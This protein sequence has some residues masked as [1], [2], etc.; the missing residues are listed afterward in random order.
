LDEARAVLEKG[1]SRHRGSVPILVSLG[2]CYSRL[3]RFEEA[4]ACYEHAQKLDPHEPKI[5]FNKA[6]ALSNL[7]LYE[8][9]R[10]IVVALLR[11]WPGDP[12]C[13]SLMGHCYSEMGSPEEA[14]KYLKKALEHGDEDPLTYDNLYWAYRDMGLLDDAIAL[15]QESIRKFPDTYPDLYRDLAGGYLELNWVEEARIV[16][17]KGLS[18]FPYDQDLKELLGALDDDT[19]DGGREEINSISKP[20][21]VLIRD[22][23]QKR[24]LLF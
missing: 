14:A 12:M 8:D 19:D 21:L 3:K 4:L 10:D 16:V 11:E 23:R 24:R 15:A 20:V 5:L 22:L 6:G 7:G 1:L 13:N 17:R 18:V 2:N 9:A